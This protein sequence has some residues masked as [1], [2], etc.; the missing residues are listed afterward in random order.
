MLGLLIGVGAV[1]MV[2]AVGNGSSKQ[3]QDNLTRLGT[4]TLNII[5]RPSFGTAATTT[6]ITFT[7]E[8]IEALEDESL[9]PDVTEVA[10][11][12]NA[13]STA[14][15]E[16]ATHTPGSIIGT[17][18][19]YLEM[20]DYTMA[21]GA[22]FT[23]ADQS[24]HRRVVLLG[25]VVVD[26]LFGT[27]DPIGAQIK[28]GSANWQVV[29]VFEEKGSNGFQDLDDAI[30]APIGAVQDNLA[31]GNTI[32]SITVQ[33]ASTEV[34]PAAQAQVTSVLNSTHNITGV[35][36]LFVLN[37]ASLLETSTETSDVFT[38]L[39]AAVA[40][41]SL[42]VGGIGVM[43]IMLV[44]VTERT[45]EIGIR[46]AVGARRADIL[47]QFLIEAVLL[48]IVGG[49]LGVIGGV[50]GSQFKVVDV[51]PVVVPSSALLAFATAVAVGLFFG[52][53]P[54]SRASGLR[55]IEALRHE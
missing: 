1:I 43:N 9:A 29:G 25:Q 36:P 21:L 17:T 3:V 23:D 52:I 51:Q 10:P 20:R 33:G 42:L 45:R 41:I 12:A 50:I 53:Y 5:N 35:S 7:D 16:G 38:T 22:P 27:Q 39:L 4:N 48:S 18:P 8:D 55:P 13:S 24:D 46:K 15:Y 44:T 28:L 54:A 14:T 34:M 40:A 2:V 30:I 32:T 6:R 37:Q 26:T 11:V 31:G 19:N 49:I 47:S